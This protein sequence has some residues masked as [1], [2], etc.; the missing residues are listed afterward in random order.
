LRRFFREQ[1]ADLQM[2]HIQFRQIMRDAEV[3]DAILPVVRGHHL[4]E[5]DTE[6]AL[7]KLHV[8]R[9]ANI[10]RISVALCP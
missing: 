5:A 1:I 2:H 8:P 7:L 4:T 9:A 10:A 6:K 3:A